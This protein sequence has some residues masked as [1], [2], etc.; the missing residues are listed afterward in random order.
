MPHIPTCIHFNTLI[1]EQENLFQSVKSRISLIR[2]NP[3]LTNWA[4]LEKS[5][6]SRGELAEHSIRQPHRWLWGDSWTV[7][8]DVFR[9]ISSKENSLTLTWQMWVAP[10]P[11][12]Q[13]TKLHNS[14]LPITVVTASWSYLTLSFFCPAYYSPKTSHLVVARVTEELD[15]LSSPSIPWYKMQSGL[16]SVNDD[17]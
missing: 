11:E 13:A 12:P 14:F 16:L 7:W 10:Y 6:N 17:Y 5:V 1:L 2:E 3:A 15:I 8:W 4:I 9:W